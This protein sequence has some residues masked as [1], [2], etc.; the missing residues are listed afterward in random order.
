VIRY[1]RVIGI[2]GAWK[3]LGMNNLMVEV[4]GRDVHEALRL[5]RRKLPFRPVVVRKVATLEELN[6]RG[7]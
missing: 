7:F 2:P 1:V 5:A 6:A 3:I 4:K